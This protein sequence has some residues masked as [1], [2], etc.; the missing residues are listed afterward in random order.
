MARRARQPDP[1]EAV[2]SRAGR[3]CEYCRA[4]QPATG[5]RYH[6]EHVFPE[7]LGG[8]D[9]VDTGFGLSHV[10]LPQIQPSPRVDEEGLAGRPLFNPR[11]DRW[12]E[13]F[14]FGSST[15]QLKGKTATG[16]GTVNRLR[17]NNSM[18]LRPDGCGWNWDSIPRG[19]I[20]GCAS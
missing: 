4:P 20:R 18:S 9:D 16:K 11:K 14:E 8:T 10:Q 7:S 13:H 17:M 1:R 15:L 2:E 6:L 19:E 3:R 12:H 5:I